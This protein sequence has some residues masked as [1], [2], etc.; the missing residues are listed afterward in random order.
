MSLVTINK[1]KQYYPQAKIFFV[2]KYYDS[3]SIKLPQL[4]QD[5]AGVE[6]V[7]V[8]QLRATFFEMPLFVILSRIKLGRLAARISVL[9]KYFQSCDYVIDVGG[10]TF[11]EERGLSGL[12]INATWVLLARSAG[13]PLLKLSQAFGPQEK[14]WYRY[15]SGRLLRRVQYLIARGSISRNVL[16]RLQLPGKVFECSDLAFLLPAEE[17]SSTKEHIKKPDKLLI[18]IAPSSV[19]Y[20]K[21]GERPYIKLMQTVIESLLGKY[22]ESDIWLYAHSYREENTL[23]NNDGPVCSMI[24]ATLSQEAG[25]RTKVIAGDFSPEEM[26][27]LIGRADIFLACRFHAMVSALSLGIPTAVLGWSHKYREVQ[28]QFSQD[29]CIDYKISS[30]ELI[31]ETVC[32][33]IENKAELREVILGNLNEV[34]KSSAENFT[35]LQKFVDNY[36]T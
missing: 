3:E 27:A 36:Q 30:P 16:D 22:P 34:I 35:I 13:K 2:S 20:R 21:L 14:K 31:I 33:L 7:P 8:S 15:I 19:L 11:S 26:R 4:L 5:P 9:A 32:N 29:Q 12:L 10:I 17:S 23:S 18:G 24:F 6:L 28:M 1:I 25:S